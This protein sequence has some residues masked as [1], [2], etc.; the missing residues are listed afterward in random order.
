MII[1]HSACP[2]QLKTNISCFMWGQKISLRKFCICNWKDGPARISGDG[3]GVLDVFHIYFCFKLH[4]GC[5][6]GGHFCFP[7]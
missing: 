4:L 1:V 7:D 3:P 5:V 2:E 6:S